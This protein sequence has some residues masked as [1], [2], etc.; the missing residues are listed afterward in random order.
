[1]EVESALQHHSS[2]RAAAAGRSGS[3]NKPLDDDDDDDDA[4]DVDVPPDSSTPLRT[5]LFGGLGLS[6]IHVRPASRGRAFFK[7]IK[8]KE[9]LRRV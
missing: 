7:K 6:A 5:T 9:K 8:M 4:D 1:M 2:S 3:M